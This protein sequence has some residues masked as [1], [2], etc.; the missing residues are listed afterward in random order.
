MRNATTTLWKLLRTLNAEEKK[1]TEKLLLPDH[2]R[3]TPTHEQKLFRWLQASEYPNEAEA[4]KS[5]H[6]SIDANTFRVVRNNLYR[7][8]LIGMREAEDKELFEIHFHDKMKEGY[9]LQQK[10][11]SEEAFHL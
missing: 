11:L 10:G 2:P 8:M 9:V 5:L 6:G 3:R 7:K 1:V 4:I